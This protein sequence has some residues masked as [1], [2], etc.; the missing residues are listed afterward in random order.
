[1]SDVAD[2]SAFVDLIKA[3]VKDHGHKN[4]CYSDLKPFLI[5]LDGDDAKAVVAAAGSPLTAG[6]LTRAFQRHDESAADHVAAAKAAFARYGAA[7][8]AGVKTALDDLLGL[9]IMSL[10]DA[11][12]AQYLQGE[13]SRGLLLDA[14]ALAEMGAAA[15][16][17]SYQF[18]LLI[19]T[20]GGALGLPAIM[21][22]QFKYLQM[23]NL[24][25]E[26][27]PLLALA[28]L[29]RFGGYA[30]LREVAVNVIEYHMEFT[31][32]YAS[33]LALS[34]AESVHRVPELVDACE[35]MTRSIIGAWAIVD[36]VRTELAQAASPEAIADVRFQHLLGV[37]RRPLDFWRTGNQDRTLLQ[38]LHPL[39]RCSLQETCSEQDWRYFRGARTQRTAPPPTR[40][41]CACACVWN[42]LRPGEARPVP[43]YQ[44]QPS[45][46]E[47]L[48]GVDHRSPAEL[49]LLALG[50]HAALSV[51]ATSEE[52][53]ECR[54]LAQEAFSALGALEART[55]S[56]WRR[57][58]LDEAAVRCTFHA[59]EVACAV[60]TCCSSK[61]WDTLEEPATVATKLVS[62]CFEQVRG[63]PITLGCDGLSGVWALLSGPVAILVPAVLRCA[64]QMPAKG[65]KKPETAAGSRQAARALLSAL[66]TSMTEALPQMDADIDLSIEEPLSSEQDFTKVRSA[67]KKHL[68][69]LKDTLNVQLALLKKASF[70]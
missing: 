16:P 32:H 31:R 51:E 42:E 20:I 41:I 52:I 5:F 39:P 61:V 10:I 1:M 65:K 46:S 11:D 63:D 18:Q 17:E 2:R 66:Q 40:C 54:A 9:V 12:R 21:M 45:A 56:A 62:D 48:L 28:P 43:D 30:D 26:S 44:H 23:K 55:F 49:R 3:Y 19:L 25:W 68:A 36:S 38:G 14:M 15:S 6:R 47:E 8:E 24:L 4:Y 70:K 67:F 29:H 37:A 35:G 13:R 33:A 57:S 60:A 34:V 27:V 58:S 59:C 69:A 64:S 50:L 22:E 53:A 7:K